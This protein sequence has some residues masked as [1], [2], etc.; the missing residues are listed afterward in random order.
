METSAHVSTEAVEE[1]EK[2]IESIE[3]DESNSEDNDS[4]DDDIKEIECTSDSE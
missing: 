4:F 2:E 1:Y 3:D